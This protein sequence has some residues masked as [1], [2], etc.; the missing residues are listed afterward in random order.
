[1]IS[2]NLYASPDARRIVELTES[3]MENGEILKAK[4]AKYP[5]ITQMG[6]GSHVFGTNGWAHYGFNDKEGN[7]KRFRL[8]VADPGYLSL[9]GIKVKEGRLFEPGNTLDERQGVLLNPAAVDLLGLENP[10]G[11][12]LPSDEFGDHQILGVTE[13]FHFSSL[14]NSIE[15]LV[16]VQNPLPILMGISDLDINDPLVPKLVFRYKGPNLMKAT[17]ILQKEWEASFPNERWDYAFVD[18]RIKSQYESEARMNKLIT[19][20]TILSIIIAA[21]GLLGL[22]LLVVNSKVKEI[23]I[24]KVMGASSLS[25]FGLLA[26]GFSIQ[27]AIA[28]ALSIPLTVMLMERWLAN[29]AYRT[30]IGVGLFVVSALAA[31]AIAGLVI[32]YQAVRASRVNPVDSLRTE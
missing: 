12:L 19:V 11:G 3:A 26:R 31:M 29:F 6:M 18:E 17:D 15:P 25:I 14:H 8:L 1:V 28:V 30:E 27:I 23:G 24:R 21:L 5:E 22:S 32:S 16:I 9:F 13:E 2:A 4:L 7:F 20:A 10:V